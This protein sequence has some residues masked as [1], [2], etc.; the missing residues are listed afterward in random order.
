M[1]ICGCDLHILYINYEM[2]NIYFV[3][4][5]L[6]VV[7]MENHNAISFTIKVFETLNNIKIC[8]ESNSSCNEIINHE[9]SLQSLILKWQ[10]HKHLFVTI[11]DVWDFVNMLA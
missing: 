4:F 1:H 9:R 10:S 6:V 2:W 11:E 3:L 8:P 5:L 7:A